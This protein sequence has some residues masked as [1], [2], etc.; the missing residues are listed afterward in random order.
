MAARW[1]GVPGSVKQRMRSVGNIGKITKAMKMVA[2]SKMRVAQVNTTNSRGMVQPMLRLLGDLPSAQ[3][4]RN[5]FVPVSTDR[6]L[7]GGINTTVAKFTRGVIKAVDDAPASAPGGG[8]GGASAGERENL[9]FVLGEKGRS[10]LQR[11][12]RRS[13]A[14]TAADTGK[15]RITFSLASALADEIVGTEYDVARVIYNRF[16]S[17]INYKVTVATILSPNA[18]EREAEAGG[19]LDAYEIEGPDRAELLQDLGEFQLASTLFNALMENNCSEQ[20]S[21]MAAMESSTKNAAEML[22]KLTLTYNRTRQASITTEL[23]EIIS[24][25]TALEG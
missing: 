11:D 22:G 18:L 9:L 21:R 12:M 6:G 1:H 19:A 2:A 23:I 5:V 17:A 14:G 16:V 3:G 15:V 8:E 25:A 7:C 20:A 10:Q 4:D 13:I 24:G